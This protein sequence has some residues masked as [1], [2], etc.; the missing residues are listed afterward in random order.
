MYSKEEYV[1]MDDAA[2]MCKENVCKTKA[3]TGGLFKN[4]ANIYRSKRD[5]P[6]VWRLGCT[7]AWH[8]PP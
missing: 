2:Y 7:N 8:P 1:Q 5:Y 4:N 3:G 6:I